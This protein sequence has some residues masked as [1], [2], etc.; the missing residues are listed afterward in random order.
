[1]PVGST[2][3]EIVAYLGTDAGRTLCRW[4]RANGFG[5][6]I[7]VPPWRGSDGYSGSALHKMIVHTGDRDEP[8]ILKWTPSG[9]PNR[10]EPQR[11]RA[12]GERAHVVAQPFP[13]LLTGEDATLM[14]QG[15][16]GDGV[17]CVSLGELPDEFKAPAC[18]AVL[19]EI[20]GR[21]NSAGFKAETVRASEF[22]RGQLTIATG[23]TIKAWARPAG[24]LDVDVP[25]ITLGTGTTVYPNPVLMASGR[26]PGHDP[27]FTAVLGRTHGD[28]HGLNVL[29]PLDY[30]GSPRV[31]EFWLIDL[32]GSEETGSI[33]RDPVQLMLSVAAAGI[34]ALS[35]QRRGDLIDA[36]VRSGGRTGP[37]VE[38]AVVS[39]VRS[40]VWP[41]AGSGG[42]RTQYLLT[43]L[44]LALWF[45]SFERLSPAARWWLVQ[46]AAEAALE[47]VDDRPKWTKPRAVR[48]PFAEARDHVESA[49]VEPDTTESLLA[50]RYNEA[51]RLDHSGRPRLALRLFESVYAQARQSLGDGHPITRASDEARSSW[52]LHHRAAQ[53]DAD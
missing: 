21:W 28:L 1:M 52:R 10:G 46:L 36:I 49:A 27:E 40:A 41:M 35:P 33:M 51:R 50:L 16:A 48:D 9:G 5:A 8:V 12:V 44:A 4:L 22:L 11:H 32:A 17:P 37:E 19:A 38:F 23:G 31:E 26:M 20:L 3:S 2:D 53:H 45:T 24:L 30:N 6:T 13:A 39:G 18:A 43:V 15:I 29:I 14:F 47:A 34:G 7:P 42:G 25:W